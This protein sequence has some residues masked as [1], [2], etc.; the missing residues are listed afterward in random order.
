M[1]LEGLGGGEGERETNSAREGSE[2]A[3]KSGGGGEREEVKGRERAPP[4]LL[5]LSSLASPSPF[6]P[7]SLL[8]PLPP[9][10]PR[11]LTELSAIITPTS[12]CTYEWG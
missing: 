7:P 1:E 12:T 5:P 8:P 10:M 2:V 3:G 9:T 6:P 11:R 4:S